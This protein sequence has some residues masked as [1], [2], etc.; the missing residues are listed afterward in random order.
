MGYN[1]RDRCE[2]RIKT[3]EKI[4]DKHLGSFVELYDR[5]KLGKYTELDA[6]HLRQHAHMINKEVGMYE[7]DLKQIAPDRNST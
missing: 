3:A 1:D 5:I 7:L 6:M 2:S 4:I